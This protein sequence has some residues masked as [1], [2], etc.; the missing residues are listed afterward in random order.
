MLEVTFTPSKAKDMPFMNFIPP[1]FM[2]NGLL[3]HVAAA[4]MLT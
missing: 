2:I 3:E 4:S 1:K